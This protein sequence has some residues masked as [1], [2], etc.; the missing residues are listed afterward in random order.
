M[1]APESSKQVKSL[2]VWKGNALHTPGTLV[3]RLV[4]RSSKSEVGSWSSGVSEGGWNLEL[5]LCDCRPA[6]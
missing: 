3:R 5:V 2:S 1:R 4:R 6:R